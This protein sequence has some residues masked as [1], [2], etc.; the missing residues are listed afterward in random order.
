MFSEKK[1]AGDFV[2]EALNKIGLSSA[3]LGAWLG[4]PCNCEERRL[5]LNAIDAWARRVVAGRVD[6]AKE[7]LSL[8]VGDGKEGG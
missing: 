7:Y 1:L 4:R 8:I 5:K 2:E 3:I 6:R